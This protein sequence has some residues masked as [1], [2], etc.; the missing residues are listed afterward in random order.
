MSIFGLFCGIFEAWKFVKLQVNFQLKQ[1]WTP[2]SKTNES[3]FTPIS[4][5]APR[6]GKFPKPKN[7]SQEKRHHD[8]SSSG[9]SWL[10][11]DRDEEASTRERS[12]SPLTTPEK[13]VGMEILLKLQSF[14]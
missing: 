3:T 6:L 10:I 2:V 14:D 11:D 7:K 12:R 8:E 13:S 4:S 9:S 5:T 1:T